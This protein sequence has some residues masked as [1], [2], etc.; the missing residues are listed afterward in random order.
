MDELVYRDR[1]LARASHHWHN[2]LVDID[3]LREILVNFIEWGNR[4]DRVKKALMYGRAFEWDTDSPGMP[5]ES[6]VPELPEDYQRL[7]HA[8]LGIATEG[9]EMMEAVQ[10]LFFLVDATRPGT[11]DITNLQEEFGDANWY[12]T[13]GLASLGQTAA[14]NRAQNDA[15]LEARF[16]GTVFTEEAANERDL[17]RERK[18]LE[19]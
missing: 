17:E 8:M 15:K 3:D 11:F 9:V 6:C 5:V 12:Y 18:E 13:F 2:T 1:V 14:E 4:L 7:I 19:S 16:G 10:Q